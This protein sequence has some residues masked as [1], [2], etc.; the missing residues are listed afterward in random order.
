[1][2]SILIPSR[3][4]ELNQKFNKI[5]YI[6]EENSLVNINI[7]GAN[8]Y[9][10]KLKETIGEFLEFVIY[11]SLRALE[12]SKKYNSKQ[13][14]IHLHLENC[15]PKNLNVRMVKYIYTEVCKIFEDTTHKIYIYSNTNFCMIAFKLI[16][17]F[18]E[19]ETIK[20]LEFINSKKSSRFY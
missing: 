11:I 9:P 16:K 20:K 1:M 13:Y 12:K 2:T 3:F 14:D 6:N 18:L 4:E 17:G 5:C 10:S 15:S 19:K 8:F 7:I